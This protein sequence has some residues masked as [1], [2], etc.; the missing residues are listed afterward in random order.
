[1]ATTS[2]VPAVKAALVT[3]FNAEAG[4][5]LAHY[6]WHPSVGSEAIFFGQVLTDGDAGATEI[7][8]DIPVMKAGRKQRD[9]TYTLELTLLN[10]R[11]GLEPSEAAAAELRGFE[12]LAYVEDVLAND[13][14][15][16][17]AAVKTIVIE[18]ISAALKAAGKGWTSEITV[19]LE[20]KARLT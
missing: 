19:R 20:V 18:S 15:A 12:L 9:E 6:S 10:V 3:A 2:T 5:E 13:P 8:H 16:G 1:M 4:D 7:E 14:T 11:E 17:I